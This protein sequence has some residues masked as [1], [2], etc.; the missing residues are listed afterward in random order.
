[1][2]WFERY[3]NFGSKQCINHRKSNILKCFHF[4][5]I[6]Y[7]LSS[8]IIFIWFLPRLLVIELILVVNV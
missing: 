7:N 3:T 4:T 8:I 5:A 1:M 6:I 2:Q